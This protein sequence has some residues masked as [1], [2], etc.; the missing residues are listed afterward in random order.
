M[1]AK[2]IP[3]NHDRFS[4]EDTIK[5]SEL[6]YHF[7]NN[8]R[9]VR[10]FSA[11]PIPEQVI[12]NILLSASTAPSGANKQPWT[13][14]VVTN[15]EI[16]SK[17]RIEAEKEEYVSYHGRMPE[18]WLEDLSYLG[19]DWHKPF[20]E[21]APVLIVVF[22]KS[23]NLENGIKTNNYYVNESVGIACGFLLEAIHYCGLVALTHTP[24]PMNFLQKLLNR[25]ENE[26]PYL[27][28]PVGF[29]ATGTTVPNIRRKELKEI[30]VWF[31]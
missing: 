21:I 5:R 12:N 22:R 31:K 17:I 2:F 9:T 14:C 7:F 3:Y 6:H 13:F 8:R 11:E 28:I 26:K 16:K 29:P 15:S 20:L 19:T 30:C 18:E 24:S 10:E 23:Y 27:L 1:K 4:V 25:P